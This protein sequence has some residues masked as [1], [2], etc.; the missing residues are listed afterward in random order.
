MNRF[1][2]THDASSKVL[3]RFSI[4]HAWWSRVYEYKF[5]EQFLNKNDLVLDFGCGIEHP[6]KFHASDI[7]QEV[8][9]F[10]TDLR[11]IQLKYNDNLK[12]ICEDIVNF[13]FKDRKFD[14]IFSISVLEH[15]KLDYIEKVIKIFES[16]LKP[17]GTLILTIDY[18]TLLPFELLEIFQATDLRTVSVF[19]NNLDDVIY[20]NENKLSVYNLVLRK[21][22]KIKKG[23]E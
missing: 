6:F 7:V 23:R 11:L 15:L 20:N 13:D 5:C 18:P 16:I 17:N 21:K 10:D 2:R 3:G 9:A 12:F 4:P 22:K 8:Y 19:D 14:K 1:F